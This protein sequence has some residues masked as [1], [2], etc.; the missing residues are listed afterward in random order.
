MGREKEVRGKKEPQQRWKEKREQGE[1]KCLNYTGRSFWGKL[2][3]RAGYT[4][5]D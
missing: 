5:Y 3:V 4:T 1:Q 2:R